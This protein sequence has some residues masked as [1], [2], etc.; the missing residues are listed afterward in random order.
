MS[1]SVLKNSHL[2]L[3]MYIRTYFLLVSPNSFSYSVDQLN[4]QVI[5]CIRV[6]I[7][8]TKVDFKTQQSQ[9]SGLEPKTT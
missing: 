8:I 5:L 7:Y 9:D 2:Q 1:R 3:K 6:A 4:Y